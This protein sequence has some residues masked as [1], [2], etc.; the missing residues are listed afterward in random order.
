MKT[1]KYYWLLYHFMPNIKVSGLY[2][3]LTGW[4]LVL[5]LQF[6]ALNF[7]N[8]YA[9]YF[10]CLQCDWLFHLKISELNKSMDEAFNHNGVFRN[11]SQTAA[12]FS[13]QPFSNCISKEHWTEHS[14]NDGSVGT[15][16]YSHLHLLI[17]N[18]ARYLVALN[19]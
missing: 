19:Q 13:W 9:N 15:M 3:I 1:A 16:S 11:K 18:T 5:Y 17:A 2:S 4:N 7:R 6:K 10:C 14:K 8:K 12:T